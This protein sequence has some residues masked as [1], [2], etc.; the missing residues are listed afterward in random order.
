MRKLCAFLGGRRNEQDKAR[1]HRK[2]G[3]DLFGHTGL[4]RIA[5]TQYHAAYATSLEGEET[6]KTRLALTALPPLSP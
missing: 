6:S 5:E 2:G 3:I 4:M 1:P